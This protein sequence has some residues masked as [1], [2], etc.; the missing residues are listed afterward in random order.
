[1]S[2][3]FTLQIRDHLAGYLSGETSIDEFKDWLIPATWDIGER[4]DA[5]A[6]D[7]T[8]EIKL[9]LAEHS[10]GYIMEDDAR[11]LLQPLVARSPAPVGS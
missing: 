4:H 9:R 1:M 8:Y 6:E 11:R 2:S 7:L 3:A 10:S 5:A